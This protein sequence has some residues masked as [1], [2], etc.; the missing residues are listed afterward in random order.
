MQT[1]TGSPSGTPALAESRTSARVYQVLR[2]VAVVMFLFLF[3]PGLNPA[4]QRSH[5]PQP[6]VVHGG[7][8]P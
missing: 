6:V 8:L 7:H 1:K 2:L 4:H 3:L 5:Q